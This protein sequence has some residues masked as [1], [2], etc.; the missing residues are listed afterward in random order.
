MER[1]QKQSVSVAKNGLGAPIGFL[2]HG[3]STNNDKLPQ[4]LL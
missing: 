4:T 2:R 1:F 3:R